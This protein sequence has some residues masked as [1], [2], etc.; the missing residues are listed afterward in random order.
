MFLKNTGGVYSRKTHWCKRSWK[1]TLSL[2][3]GFVTGPQ[4]C[5]RYKPSP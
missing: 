1:F 5:G 4:G 3:K 2:S